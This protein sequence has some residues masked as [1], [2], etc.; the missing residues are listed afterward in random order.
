MGDTSDNIPGIPGV[1][2][3]TALK[4]LHE[5]GTVENVLEHASQIKGKMGEKVAAHAD[6]ARMSKELATIY[7]RC[8]SI[9]RSIRSLMRVTTSRRSG[10]VP[11]AGIQIAAGTARF[12]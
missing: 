4:L 6:D 3:K 10:D 11:Q 7:A 9:C 8:R 5:Y 2:E 1:G 12:A